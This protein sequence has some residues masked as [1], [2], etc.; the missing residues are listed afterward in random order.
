MLMSPACV[1]VREVLGADESLA[2]LVCGGSGEVAAKVC[3][4]LCMR[5]FDC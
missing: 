1:L 5:L 3:I 4:M 2:M